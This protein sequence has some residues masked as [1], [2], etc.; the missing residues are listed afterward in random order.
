MAIPSC[1]SVTSYPIQAGFVPSRIS[2]DRGRKC[3]G[4]HRIRRER[5]ELHQIKWAHGVE[6]S[7]SCWRGHRWRCCGCPPPFRG[8]RERN[9]PRQLR[10]TGRRTVIFPAPKRPRTC[11]S[12]DM[13]AGSRQQ[14]LRC[15]TS[16]SRPPWMAALAQSLCYAAPAYLTAMDVGNARGL[17]EQSLPCAMVGVQTDCRSRSDQ[18]RL[19]EGE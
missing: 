1:C 5:D 4:R 18:D 12:G 7:T 16:C 2:P 17:Q 6:I 10:T 14:L 15:S 3:D 19:V 8:E 9:C 13:G 11:A